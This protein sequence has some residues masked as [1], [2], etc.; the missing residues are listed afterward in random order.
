MSAERTQSVEVLVVTR[1][2]EVRFPAAWPTSRRPSGRLKTSRAVVT[3]LLGLTMGLLS[4]PSVQAAEIQTYDIDQLKATPGSD[5]FLSK[6]SQD[7]GAGYRGKTI[8]YEQAFALNDSEASYARSRGWLA[9]T[10]SGQEI[11]PANIP[12]V[13]LLDARIPAALEWRAG[14]IAAETLQKN[15]HGTYLDTLRSYWPDSFYDGTPCNNSHEAW[16]RASVNL[17]QAV[18]AKTGGRFVIANG[19]GLGSGKAYFGNQVAADKII[20]AAQGIQIEQWMRNTKNADLDKRFMQTMIGK[21]KM[22]FAKCKSAMATCQRHFVAS[23]LT[24]LSSTS[25]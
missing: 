8:N 18:K 2:T 20:N 21:G 13:T 10:C 25:S 16:N 1:P 15:R 6:G 24:Y 7:P 14:M 9:K 11:S 19:A 12:S 3:G 4:F 22:V 5:A 17:V 23:P